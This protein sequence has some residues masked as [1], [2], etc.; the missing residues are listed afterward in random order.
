MAKGN[1]W[2]KGQTTIYKHTHKTKY[3]VTRTIGGVVQWLVPS[4][5]NLTIIFNYSGDIYF[6]YIIIV[7]QLLNL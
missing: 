6:V 3:R 7:W 1:K 5:S 4:C 2:Q